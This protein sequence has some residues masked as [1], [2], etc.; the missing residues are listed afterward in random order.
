[1]LQS[2]VC[3]ALECAL[4]ITISILIRLTI[5]LPLTSYGFSTRNYVAVA[6]IK[7]LHFM[8]STPDP[9]SGHVSR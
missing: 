7:V 9:G 2:F 5:Q 4:S 8:W 1:M 3:T 6:T